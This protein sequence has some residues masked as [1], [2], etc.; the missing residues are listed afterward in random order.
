MKINSHKVKQRLHLIILLAVVITPSFAETKPKAPVVKAEPKLSPLLV[1][2]AGRVI[3]TKADWLK[4]REQIRREWLKALGIEI[5][6]HRVPLN[7]EILKTEELPTF[8]RQ[9]VRYQVEKDVFTDGYLLTPKN[10]RGKAPAIVV[11]HPTTALQAKGVAGL[12][13]EYAEEKRQG[14]QLVARGYIVWCPRNFI[15]EDVP[16]IADG[17]KLYLAN[18]AKVHKRNPHRTGMGRMVFDAV[19]AADFLE[20]LPNVDAKKIGGIGHS[21]GGKQ[22][23]Y[24]AAFDERYQA[25][26]SSEGGIGLS[27]SNWEADW[28]LGTQIKKSSWHLE[29]HQVLSLIAP[30]A[31]FLLAGD[32]ADDQRS[33]MFIE[34]VRPIYR[35]FNVEK[36]IGWLDHHQ[37]HRYGP[38]AR[39]AA[40]T[41]L[42]THLKSG[43]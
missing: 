2:D 25:A 19:R 38:E 26:V 33:S 42:G 13:P 31:F 30:R 21:L 43:R 5:P 4:R 18:V 11:F 32:S 8:T 17:P 7:T 6:F 27:F 28:Y 36:S 15:F 23:V 20:S 29:N 41:F 22:V 3:K 10:L 12:A 24:A 14:L 39:Q 34:V 9:L 40:E 16:K 37:G 35:L 1:D